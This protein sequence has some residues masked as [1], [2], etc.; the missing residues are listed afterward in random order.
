M[1]PYIPRCIQTGHVA[2]FIVVEGRPIPAFQA[3][4][5]VDGLDCLDA[6][7]CLPAGHMLACGGPAVGLALWWGR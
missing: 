4:V 3:Y 5:D 6:P 2:G 7:P 1:T